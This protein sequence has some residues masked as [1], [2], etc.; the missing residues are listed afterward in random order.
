MPR[1]PADSDICPMLPCLRRSCFFSLSRITLLWRI[2]NTHPYF[3]CGSVSSHFY[4]WLSECR[5]DVQQRSRDA[6]E[7]PS[8]Y[9]RLVG[10][11]RAELVDEFIDRIMADPPG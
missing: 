2:R 1:H 3:A 10:V 7:K 5:M 6:A 8:L 9:E 4:S 11:Y